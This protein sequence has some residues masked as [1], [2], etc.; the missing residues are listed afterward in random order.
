MFQKEVKDNAHHIDAGSLFCVAQYA[1]VALCG[2]SRAL[3]TMA[4]PLLAAATSEAR[5]AHRYTI[6]LASSL[7][8]IR[9]FYY[10]HFLF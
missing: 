10:W 2:C 3:L 5:L 9:N 6:G 1:L 7:L 8:D 4:V